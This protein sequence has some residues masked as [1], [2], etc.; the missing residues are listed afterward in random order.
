M[1]LFQYH[2]SIVQ[3]ALNRDS[4]E[5]IL[6]VIVSRNLDTATFDILFLHAGVSVR[7]CTSCPP[8]LATS[9]RRGVVAELLD[10]VAVDV[11]V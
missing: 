2:L 11:S 6:G 4:A 9:N 5:H 8:L 3:G 7:A 10:T 1:S